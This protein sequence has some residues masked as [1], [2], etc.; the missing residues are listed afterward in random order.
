[1]PRLECGRCS[2]RD[3][4]RLTKKNVYI[5]GELSRRA[6]GIWKVGGIWT[7]LFLNLYIARART[8]SAACLRKTSLNGIEVPGHRYLIRTV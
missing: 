1:M 6:Y 2:E 3:R 4:D 8:T 5:D 7:I